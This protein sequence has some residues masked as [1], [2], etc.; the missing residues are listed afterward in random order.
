MPTKGRSPAYPTLSKAEKK[1]ASERIAVH[2]GH[3]D[4]TPEQA[5]A[6]GLREAAPEKY[7]A[8]DK[9]RKGSK[10]DG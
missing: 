7:A 6:I 9:K 4:H 5:V 1:K 2:M 10:G 8:F 3:S